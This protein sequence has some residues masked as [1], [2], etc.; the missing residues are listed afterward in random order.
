MKL[1][2][3]YSF[4]TFKNIERRFVISIKYQDLVDF[5]LRFD[6]LRSKKGSKLYGI[7]T[8]FELI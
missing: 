8:F 2:A 5:T 7:E 6:F 1:S 4:Y 3:E